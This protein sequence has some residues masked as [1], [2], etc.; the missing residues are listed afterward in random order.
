MDVNEVLVKH[1]GSFGRYQKWNCFLLGMLGFVVSFYSYEIVFTAAIP[2]HWCSLPEINNTQRSN[3]TIEEQKEL[4]IPKEE[5]NG[6]V[7]YSSC[8]VYEYNVVENGSDQVRKKE[9]CSKW[10]Y[11]QTIFQS[12]I[13]SEVCNG[14]DTMRARIRTT[15]SRC[16]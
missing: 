7:V 11:D 9:K 6:E 15:I 16:I 3:L 4:L 10:T 14:V 2:D 12:T 5:K 1:V 13:V 8:H